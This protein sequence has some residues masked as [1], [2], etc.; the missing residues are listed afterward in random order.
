MLVKKLELQRF[1]HQTLLRLK[2]NVKRKR[3]SSIKIL[4]SLLELVNISHRNLKLK[5]FVKKMIK[6]KIG[7]LNIKYIR[8]F[9][10]S[11]VKKLLRRG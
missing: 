8:H 5:R 2:M 11:K 4:K 6:T 3:L 7:Q 1:P 10:H 9:F